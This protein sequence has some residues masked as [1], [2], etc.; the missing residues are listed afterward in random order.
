MVDQTRERMITMRQEKEEE[1]SV[2]YKDVTHLVTLLGT[3]ISAPRTPRSSRQ[4]QRAYAPST[5]PREHYLRI[6]AIPFCGHL[7]AEFHNRFNP[8][9]ITDTESLA[10]L[11]GIIKE[12]GNV[13][14]VV[15]ELMFC[16]SD[17]PNVFAS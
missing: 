7:S 8:E 10:L 16:E 1:Y 2:W 5:S 6:L 4:M 11:P 14:H 17:M 12:T 15:D 9:S 3:S 13:Q